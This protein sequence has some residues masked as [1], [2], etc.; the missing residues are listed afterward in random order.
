[1]NPSRKPGFI[2]FRTA[3]GWSR[4]ARIRRQRRPCA[5]SW[6]VSVLSTPLSTE[7]RSRLKPSFPCMRWV[8]LVV[9]LF[10][11]LAWDIAENYG[12]YTHMISSEIDD[13]GRRFG[14][15]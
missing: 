4:V 15:W 12:H 3:R 10:V 13:L 7:E 11:F 1:M 9:L 2:I 6:F 5:D 14:L 8:F